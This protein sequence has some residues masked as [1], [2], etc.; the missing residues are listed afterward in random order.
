LLS[1]YVLISMPFCHIF[2]MLSSDIFLL[3]NSSSFFDALIFQGKKIS[4]RVFLLQYFLPSSYFLPS[5]L[6]F[7]LLP[8]LRCLFSMPFSLHHF[9]YHA[10]KVSRQHVLPAIAA[11]PRRSTPCLFPA[12]PRACPARLALMAA[13]APVSAQFFD[14][15]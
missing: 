3:M 12:M 9:S 15:D 14:A 13:R 10:D 11:Q 6:L 4:V 1:E 5:V 2:L 8:L 7:I